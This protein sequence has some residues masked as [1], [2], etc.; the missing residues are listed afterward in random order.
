M[1]ANSD[2]SQLPPSPP[3]PETVLTEFILW[4]RRNGAG[5]NACDT[6]MEEV[7]A[8]LASSDAETETAEAESSAGGWN[9]DAGEMV[10]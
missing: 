7:Y 5:D 4:L 6:L 8:F 3:T 1:Q 2:S 10:G 9:D